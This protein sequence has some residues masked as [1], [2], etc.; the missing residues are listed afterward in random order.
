MSRKALVWVGLAV[1]LLLAGL[2]SYYA[3]SSPDGLEKVAEDEGF[4]DSAEDSAVADSPLAD[5]GVEGV[6]NERAAVGL[7]GIVG[8]AVTFV[9]AGGLFYL[10]ARRRPAAVE[11]AEARDPASGG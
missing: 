3:S 4:I 6:D 2:A 7:A 8:V 9:V 5:Y 10:V 1:A 11:P